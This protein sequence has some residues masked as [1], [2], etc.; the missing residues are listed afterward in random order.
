MPIAGRF[1]H[2][3]SHQLD[4]LEVISVGVVPIWP[5]VG[6]SKELTS[7]GSEPGEGL[8]TKGQQPHTYIS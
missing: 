5:Q 1:G 2:T 4:D 3:S 8:R 6:V 7:D